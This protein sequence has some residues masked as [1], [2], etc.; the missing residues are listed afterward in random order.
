MQ[1]ALNRF[2]E[3]IRQLFPPDIKTILEVGCGEG[4]SAEA[5]L[6]NYPFERGYGGDI[7]ESALQEAT[8]RFSRF[9]YVTLSAAT[10]PFPSKSV[11]L[12]FSTETFEH[13]TPEDAIRATQEVRRIA[14]QYVLLSVPNEPIFRLQRMMQGKNIRQWG[15]HPEHI[16]HWSLAGFQRFLKAQGLTVIQATSPLPWAWSI[17]LCKP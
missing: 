1:L 13:L 8:R 4:F 12:V 2:H 9:H 14:T 3:R 16:N 17:V 5:V 11:D 10:L 7:S 6:N 15:D